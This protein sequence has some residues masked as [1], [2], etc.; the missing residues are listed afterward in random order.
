MKQRCDWVPENDMYKKYHD[1]EWGVPVYDDKKL[2]EM[3]VLESAQAGLTWSTIL[4]RREGYKKSFDDFDAEE[5]AKYDEDKIEE[6]LED[7]GIIRN[8]L[9]IES[10]VIN[11]EKF[12][13]I[14]EE[15]GSFSD[16]IWQFVGGKPIINEWE[17]AD[18]LPSKTDKS[19][20]MSKRLK[21]RGFKFI[22]PTICYAYMQAVGMV[23]DHTVDCFRYEEINELT[24]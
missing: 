6:L 14:Q 21:E 5:I 2:F 20:K 23:N 19:K 24:G 17:S 10:T 3:L 18:D 8:R 11:A 12:L 16:Y 9:K 15:L 13:E 4:K 1:E 7:E 22:G